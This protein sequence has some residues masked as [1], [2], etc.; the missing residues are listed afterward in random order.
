MNIIKVITDEDFGLKSKKMKNPRLR[1]GAR[2]IIFNKSNKIAILFK[3]KKKE[4]KLM[5]GGVE[6][7]EKPD[8]AFLRES[9]EETGCSVKI[10]KN[11]GTIIEEK[12]RD[13]FKQISYVYIAKVVEENNIFNYTDKEIGEGS[14]LLWLDIDDAIKIIN[15]SENKLLPSIYDEKMS[16]YHTKFIVRRDYEILKYFVNNS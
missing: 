6:I 9:Q 13:N 12:S 3:E 5:G 7:N 2:G 10:I 8:F 16:V 4:Y 11:L 1:I 15:E 14:K